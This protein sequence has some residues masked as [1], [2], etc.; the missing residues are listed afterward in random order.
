MS[1][2]TFCGQCKSLMSLYSV[3]L[4]MYHI[5]R[6]NILQFVQGTKLSNYGV[7][8]WGFIGGKGVLEKHDGGLCQNS[9]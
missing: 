6:S 3:I 9:M 8:Y 4:C 1:P 5:K 2:D 7:F